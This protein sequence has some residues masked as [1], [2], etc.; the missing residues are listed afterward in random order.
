MRILLTTRDFLFPDFQICDISNKKLTYSHRRKFDLGKKSLVK[1][2]ELMLGET[3]PIDVLFSTNPN[4]LLLKDFL[5]NPLFF[6]GRIFK[7]W[8]IEIEDVTN[9]SLPIN[10]EFKNQRNTRIWVSRHAALA[11]VTPS[12]LDLSLELDYLRSPRKFELMIRSAENDDENKYDMYCQNE[13]KMAIKDNSQ[14][15]L[16]GYRSYENVEIISGRVIIRSDEIIPVSNYR[17]EVTIHHA[18]Y[19]A[20]RENSESFS[21]LRTYKNHE[22]IEKAI[23][24]GYSSSWFHFLIECLPRLISI[25]NEHREYTP[26]ILPKDVPRQIVSICESLT[27][28]KIIEVERLERIQILQ[29]YLGVET[30]VTDPLEFS[31]RKTAIQKAVAEIRTSLILSDDNKNMKKIYMKRPKG[32]FRPLQNEIRLLSGLTKLGFEVISPENM[33]FDEVLKCM[34]NARIIVAES[35]AALTNVL[36][37]LPGARIIELYPGKGPMTFWPELAAIAG[38]E[39]KKVMSIRCPIGPRGIARDGIYVPFKKLKKTIEEWENA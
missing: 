32:L 14:D 34:T 4:I 3:K 15:P 19:L 13:V 36:F 39:V 6:L 16:L 26:V 21:V 5:R 29:V 11:G 24:V 20:R 27:K 30:G 12:D 25:P 33:E 10:F 38:A 18:G 28:V 23:Y 17:N 31:F 7:T 1:D 35:G 37:T 2:F 22:P 8:E 9:S